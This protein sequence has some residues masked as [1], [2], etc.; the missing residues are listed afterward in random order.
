MRFIPFFDNSCRYTDGYSICGD[1][2]ANHGTCTDNSTLPDPYAAENNRANAEPG[3]IADHDISLGVQRLLTYRLAGRKA[4]IIRVKRAI[5]SHV[6]ATANMD[7]AFVCIN[8]TSRLDPGIG[9]NQKR[10]SPTG[11]NGAIAQ[12]GHPITQLHYTAFPVLIQDHTISNINMPSQP[13][14][15]MKDG[16]AGR[17]K[18][19]WVEAG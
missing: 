14:I 7:G 3:I 8:L 2:L 9:T 5:G 13:Q 12:Y 19:F 10:P 1:I 18:T 17:D 16:R 4:V 11:F 15:R 6:H